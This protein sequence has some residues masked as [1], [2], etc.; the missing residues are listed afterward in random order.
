MNFT[1]LANYGNEG[2]SSIGE[3]DGK[4]EPEGG[5]VEGYGIYYPAI[6]RGMANVPLAKELSHLSRV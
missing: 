2:P 3:N 6:S 5:R 1:R 4:G